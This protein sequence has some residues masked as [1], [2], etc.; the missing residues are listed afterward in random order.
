MSASASAD[1]PGI[2]ASSIVS[3]RLSSVLNRSCPFASVSDHQRRLTLTETTISAL[4]LALASVMVL[5]ASD[6]PL[7]SSRAPSSSAPS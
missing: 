1:E 2:L 3:E 4:P 5:T 6:L 7:S